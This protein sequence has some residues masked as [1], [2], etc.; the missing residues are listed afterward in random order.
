[1]AV[2]RYSI[3]GVKRILAELEAWLEQSQDSLDSEEGRDYP[4]DERLDRLTQRVD[5]LQQA[6]DALDE[7]E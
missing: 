2:K 6:Y 3:T 4:N 1:M 7:I 5:S